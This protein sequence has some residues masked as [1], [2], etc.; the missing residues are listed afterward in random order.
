MVFIYDIVKTAQ[1]QYTALVEQEEKVKPVNFSTNYDFVR[2]H[3]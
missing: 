2:I 3:N 1:N